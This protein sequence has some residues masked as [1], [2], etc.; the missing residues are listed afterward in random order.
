MWTTDSEGL[1][2]CG[3]SAGKPAVFRNG[4]AFD[5]RRHL[6]GVGAVVKDG[7]LSQVAPEAAAVATPSGP[8]R[9]IMI[10]VP[11][12]REAGVAMTAPNASSAIVR[13]RF[14]AMAQ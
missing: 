1:W 3:V 2:R 10:A 4:N 6:R 7:R 5:G 12:A 13:S 11:S 8:L 14:V 9:S